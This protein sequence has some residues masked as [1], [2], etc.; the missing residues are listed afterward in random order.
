MHTLLSLEDTK[1]IKRYNFCPGNMSSY[2]ILYGKVPAYSVPKPSP[3]TTVQ[4][5]TNGE[6][7]LA[8]LSNGNSGGGIIIISEGG[9]PDAGYLMEKMGL[10]FLGDANALLAFLVQQGHKCHLDSKLWDSEGNY[11]PA[12]PEPDPENV[13]RL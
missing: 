4:S 11:I 12:I 9:Y 7:M 1:M 13:H 10:K 3:S 2:D 5:E 8:W 6:Y